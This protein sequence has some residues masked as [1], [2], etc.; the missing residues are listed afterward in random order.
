MAAL[1]PPSLP[2]YETMTTLIEPDIAA[3]VHE[4]ALADREIALF[5]DFDGT[6]VEIAPSPED[7]QLDRRVAPAL[8]TLRTQL[9]GA[10]ALV[11]GRPIGFL[12]EMLAPHRFDTAGLHGAQIRVGDEILSR[13]DTHEGIRAALRD[14]VRFANSHVGIIV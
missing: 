10:L 6:L 13:A 7:V 1:L 11:S 14:L 3:N 8:T 2:R 5:L 9:G 4:I 12:D